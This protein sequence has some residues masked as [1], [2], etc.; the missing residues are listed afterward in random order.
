M[1]IPKRFAVAISGLLFAGVAGLSMA[2]IAP[3]AAATL[4]SPVSTQVM[5]LASFGDDC[6]DDWDGGGGWDD[7]DDDWDGGGWDD[8][9]DDWC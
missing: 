1:G 2:S 4:S 7:C 9:D 6:D 5:T 3:A 8:G